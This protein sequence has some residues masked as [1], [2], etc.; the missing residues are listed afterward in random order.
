MVNWP[1]ILT[2]PQNS[3]TIKKKYCHHVLAIV[4]KLQLYKI[5]VYL[6]KATS[7]SEIRN[8]QYYKPLNSIFSVKLQGTVKERKR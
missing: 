8:P 5:S 4:K 3:A 6:R 1:N 7:G 2:V